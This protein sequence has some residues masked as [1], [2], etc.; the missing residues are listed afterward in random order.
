M[1]IKDNLSQSWI[2]LEMPTN[3]PNNR[4]FREGKEETVSLAQLTMLGVLLL[5]LKREACR[6]II[7]LTV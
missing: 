5:V 7:L 1:M 4:I 3:L 2:M 6:E